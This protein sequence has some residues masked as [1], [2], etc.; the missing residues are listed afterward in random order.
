MNYNFEVNEESENTDDESHSEKLT[1]TFR[2]L[3]TMDINDEEKTDSEE[4]SK[5]EDE[6]EG[7]ELTPECIV[8]LSEFFPTFPNFQDLDSFL[9]FTI[10]SSL[11]CRKMFLL[12]AS[13]TFTVEL[14]IH[15]CKL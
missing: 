9:H 7:L 11:A 4:S 1:Q 3:F 5:Y 13:I 12:I 10:F 8:E 2:H 14:K 15:H 6:D